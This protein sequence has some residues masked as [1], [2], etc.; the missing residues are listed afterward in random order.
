MLELGRGKK[1]RPFMRVIGTKDLEIHV[2]FD[3]LIVVSLRL[4]NMELL[5][6]F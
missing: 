5:D 3:F 1:L 4:D 2:S 6:S